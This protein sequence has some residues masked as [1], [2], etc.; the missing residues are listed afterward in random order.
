MIRTGDMKV[1][2]WLGGVDGHGERRD[3]VTISLMQGQVGS[4][5]SRT[6]AGGHEREPEMRVLRAEDGLRSVEGKA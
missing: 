2:D 4:T 5:L 6:V 1:C 3:D